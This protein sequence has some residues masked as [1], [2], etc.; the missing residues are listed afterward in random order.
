[1][2]I[3]MN[4]IDSWRTRNKFVAD[5][6]LRERNPERDAPNGGAIK[7]IPLRKVVCSRLGQFCFNNVK[8]TITLNSSLVMYGIRPGK[9]NV[10]AET[11]IMSY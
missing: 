7:K 2:F 9:K 5:V 1:M 3:S 4:S 11:Q 8:N 6:Y 10:M